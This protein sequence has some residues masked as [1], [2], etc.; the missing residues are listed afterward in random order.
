MKAIKSILN[1]VSFSDVALIGGGLFIALVT[2]E[3][4]VYQMNG[5]QLYGCVSF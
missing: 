3:S 1:K 2:I 5:G 4:I